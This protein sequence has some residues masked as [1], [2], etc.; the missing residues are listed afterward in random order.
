LKIDG[1][2][3]AARKGMRSPKLDEE[4]FKSRY[5]QQFMDPAYASIHVIWP[6]ASSQ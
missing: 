6:G 2:S 3:P 5:R 4:Q 1:T